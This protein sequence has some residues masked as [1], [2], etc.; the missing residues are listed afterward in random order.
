MHHQHDAPDLASFRLSKRDY[1]LGGRRIRWVEGKADWRSYLPR[2]SRSVRCEIKL[3]S[4]ELA[5]IVRPATIRF[6][7]LLSCTN[8]RRCVLFSKELCRA[9]LHHLVMDAARCLCG[10]DH[11]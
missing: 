11:A 1:F 6:D 4:S 9:V 10:H 2:P 3:A 7:D 8:C 5:Q